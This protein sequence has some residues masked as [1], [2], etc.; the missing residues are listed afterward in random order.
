MKANRIKQIN[1]SS[2]AKLLHIQNSDL[3]YDIVS[4]W[5]RAGSRL[6]PRGKEGMAHLFE[7]LL[8][9]KTV[10]YPNKVARLH[11]LE[12]NGIYSNAFTNREFV[13]YYHDQLKEGT[14]KSLNFLL[15]GL[16]NSI[17]DASSLES[18]KK[19]VLNEMLRKRN[20]PVKYIFDLNFRSLFKNSSLA[21]SVLGDEKSV[22]SI[23]V[24][25]MEDYRNKYYQ[26]SNFYFVIISSLPTDKFV[27]VIDKYLSNFKKLPLNF[28]KENFSRPA[29][30]IIEK[31]N[32]DQP[33]VSYSFR[34]LS[35]SV[36][37]IIILNFINDYLTDTWISRLIVR[38]RLENNLTYWVNGSNYYYHDAGYFSFAFSSEAKKLNKIFSIIK[39]ELDILK[40]KTIDQK[41][42]KAH[43]ISFKSSFI[44]NVSDPSNLLSYYGSAFVTGRQIFTVK[45]FLRHVDNITPRK[46]QAVAKK[47][48]IK[49][50][51]SVSLIG[52][53]KKQAIKI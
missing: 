34:I 6:E 46:I 20:N 14:M 48:F 26:P 43:K 28:K 50:N 4:V 15:D 42:L 10:K 27:K 35:P 13:Y 52:K 37:E 7:H 11:M 12:S 17:I 3:P 8:M 36:K 31:R 22:N 39:E 5:L 19:I 23:G 40:N 9:N 38:L 2:G 51:I 32:L 16:R 49:E 29:K 25:D 47:Y 53:I 41:A 1:L 33:Q 44:K 30:L 21:H 45:E 24:K 18:E